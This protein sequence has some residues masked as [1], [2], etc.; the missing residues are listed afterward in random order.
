MSPWTGHLLWEAP[1]PGTVG[2]TGSRRV[3]VSQ[4][5]PAVRRPG[6]K[7]NLFLGGQDPDGHSDLSFQQ[8]VLFE[9]SHKLI[10]S[11][12]LPS[13]LPPGWATS[14]GTD[15]AGQGRQP[16]GGELSTETQMPL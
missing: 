14:P 10:F 6:I 15:P 8:A 3:T 11:T 12:L 7:E 5:N 16:W 9:G 4:G 13:F 1:G 2:K